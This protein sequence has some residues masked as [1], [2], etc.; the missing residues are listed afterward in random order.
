M[1]RASRTGLLVA[2]A[3]MGVSLCGCAAVPQ[4][5]PDLPAGKVAVTGDQAAAVLD[6]Y[7]EI[8]NAANAERDVDA[9]AAVETGPLLDTSRASYLLAEANDEEPSEA[10]FHTDVRAYSPRFGEYPMWFVATSTI[11]D[12]PARVAV[13]VLTRSSASAEWL[14]E[15]AA[16]LGAVELPA[17]SS[18]DGETGA[19]TGEQTQRVED[20]LAQIYAHLAGEDAEDGPDLGIDGLRSY[21]D[22]VSNNTIDLPEVGAPEVS[23]ATDERAPVRV[24]PTE[25]GVLAVATAA[26]EVTQ[27]IKEDIQGTMSLGGELTALASGSGRTVRFVSSHPLVVTVADDGSAEVFSGGWRWADVRVS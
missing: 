4:P 22:W 15:Q 5:R 21:R 19:A 27:S 12:D 24:L 17:I 3:G 16:G 23:C 10:F 18:S 14:V 7:D 1:S 8:N 2:L 26:C 11:D 6:H 25:T 9:V 13:Q 20:V